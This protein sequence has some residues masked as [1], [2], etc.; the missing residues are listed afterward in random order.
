ME[1]IAAGVLILCGAG[2]VFAAVRYNKYLVS[3]NEPGSVMFYLFGRT[4]LRV[5]WII[6]GLAMLLA[7]LLV[8]ARGIASI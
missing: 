1:W 4:G 5:V 3:Y 8:A 7:G 2:A 6:F